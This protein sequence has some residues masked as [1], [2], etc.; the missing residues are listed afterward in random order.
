MTPGPFPRWASRMWGP[1]SCV[2]APRRATAEGGLHILELKPDGTPRDVVAQVLDYGA[3]VPS[4]TD[5]EV[6]SIYATYRRDDA[7]RY[8]FVSAGGGKWFS[9]TLRQVPV[10]ARVFTCIPKTGYVG[11]GEVTGPARPAD[12]AVLTIDGRDVP[13]RSLESN[14]P[15]RHDV[16][17]PRPGE[18]YR[19]WVLPVR[20]IST[21]D[22]EA[23]CSDPAVRTRQVRESG[24]TARSSP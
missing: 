11:I 23:P 13:F 9:R 16:A 21:V 19:E 17:G 14:G 24:S 4:P 1:P 22:R 5:D 15:Y 2:R 18:D 12:E 7:R 3:W 20:W 8:G 6:R 10:G